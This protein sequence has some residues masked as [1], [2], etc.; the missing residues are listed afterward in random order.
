M[1]DVTVDFDGFVQ[2]RL[3]TDPDPSDEP[4]GVSGWTHAAAGEPD[5][6]RVL[7][8]QDD[9]DRRVRRSRGP[10]VGV[11][12]RAVDGS[13]QNPL[14]GARVQL[15]DG[16]KFEGRN[17]II[18]S[19]G[20]EPID[21]LHLHLTG[22]GVV[23]DKQHILTDATG[24]A[25]P[26]YRIT[27]G[28]LALRTPSIEADQDAE[29]EVFAA[30]NIPNSDAAA[31]RR[32]RKQQLEQDLAALLATDVTAATAL[33][34]RIVDL[35]IGG[36]AIGTVGVRM[37]YTMAMHGPGSVTDEATVL[38]GR[39]NAEADWPLDF[40]VGGWDADA[41]CMYM[42]GRLSLPLA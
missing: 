15:L 2:V 11:A 25:V 1:P 30:L 28:E 36:P 23:L 41:L 5:L 21:P 12:V 42:R 39:V 10:S 19:D 18:A 32:A 33:R 35:D 13:T 17:W 6:D 29:R 16:P 22:A 27:P 40:W 3:A 31:W 38:P 24:G 26:F 8:V 9:D 34:L 20:F 37:R 7:I 4:R 14:V